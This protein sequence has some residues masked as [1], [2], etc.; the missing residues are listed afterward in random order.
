MSDCLK[1]CGLLAIDKPSYVRVVDEELSDAWAQRLARLTY[2]RDA[3]IRERDALRASA[4]TQSLTADRFAS[5]VAEADKLRAR[6]AELEAGTSTA[7]EGSCDAQAA[8]G[9]N[10]PETPECSAHAASVVPSVVR[11]MTDILRSDADADE[12]HAAMATLVEAVCPGWALTQAASGGGDHFADASK[13]VE[14]PRGWLKEEEREAVD[15]AR[16][17]FD[18][19]DHGDS[20]CVFIARVLKQLL[21][22]SSPPEVV[23]PFV[24]PALARIVYGR[25]SEWLEAL[26]AAGVPWKEVGRE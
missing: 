17:Y 13:M 20:E 4:I 19:D 3:A 14:Q 22:R 9:G 25:D 12:K 21:A 8:S 7:G 23:K 2:Q 6:V 26:A 16:D 5:A 24:D 18:D 15:A 10:P 1:S 11:E